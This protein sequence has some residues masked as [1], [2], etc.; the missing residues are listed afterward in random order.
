MPK[1]YALVSLN[2]T[3]EILKHVP[4]LILHNFLHQYFPKDPERVQMRF[5]VSF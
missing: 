3:I 5:S 2:K 4:P 1:I